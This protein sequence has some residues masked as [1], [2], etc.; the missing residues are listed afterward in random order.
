M[1][2]D[3]RRFD[4]HGYPWWQ[5]CHGHEHNRIT[6]FN[7]LTGSVQMRQMLLGGGQSQNRGH[8]M[9]GGGRG[10]KNIHNRQSNVVEN[11][12]S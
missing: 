8:D 1:I 2:L 11:N 12:L 10:C 5:A 4:A 6:S 9:S 7:K 3:K